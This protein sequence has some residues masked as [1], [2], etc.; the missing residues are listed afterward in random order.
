MA[1][2]AAACA[3]KVAPAMCSREPE[4]VSVIGTSSPSPD[5]ICAGDPYQSRAPPP[6][7]QRR[8]LRTIQDPVRRSHWA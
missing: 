8:I 4:Q 7:T 5:T 1:H 2:P 6:R 3:Q